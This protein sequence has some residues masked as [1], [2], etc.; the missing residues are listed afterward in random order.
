VSPAEIAM[1]GALCRERAGLK[2]PDGA[3]IVESRLDAVA[4]RAGFANVMALLGAL[5]GDDGDVLAWRVVE[6]MTC[7]ETSFFDD[8]RVFHAFET[9]IWPR[10]ARVRAGAPVRV[11]SAAC[12]TGQEIYSLAMLAEHAR[13]GGVEAR[14]DLAASDLS[15]GA[16]EQAKS[17][18]YTQFEVQRGLPIRLL[19]RH[20]EKV[21]DMWSLSADIRR[22]IRWRR[23]NLVGNLEGIGDFDVI[24]C[25]NV[26]SGMEPEFQKRVLDALALRLPDDGCL[27]LGSGEDATASAAFRPLEGAPGFYC[28]TRAYNTAAA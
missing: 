8:K 6:A 25:R 10:L 2:M 28:P 11:W 3:Y 20:F 22:Q 5:G 9:D 1:V 16:I 23:V 24:F 17:G 27:V 13:R 21:D 26:L 19:V 4:R 18:L 14:L 7:A 12:S 15:A